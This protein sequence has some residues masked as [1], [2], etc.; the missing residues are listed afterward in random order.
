MSAEL[1]LSRPES[2]SIKCAF[3]VL[4]KLASADSAELTKALKELKINDDSF[5]EHL[6]QLCHLHD[7]L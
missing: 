1:F 2:A 4:Q 3:L 5:E 7:N 6:D